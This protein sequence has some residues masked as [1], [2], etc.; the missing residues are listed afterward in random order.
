M[1][2]STQFTV[3]MHGGVPAV[4]LEPWVS[5]DDRFGVQ[6]E[7]SDTSQLRYRP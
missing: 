6:I 7:E 5:F 3:T 1:A 2:S 4:M